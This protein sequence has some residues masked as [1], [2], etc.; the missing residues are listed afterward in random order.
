MIRSR[1][2]PSM[3]R[4]V[5][6]ATLALQWLGSMSGLK[7]ETIVVHSGSEPEFNGW[8]VVPSINLATTF[9]QE[10]P[11]VK[12]GRDDPNS[13]GN[14]FFYSRQANPT[15]GAFER[16]LAATE[17][18]NFCCAFSSGCHSIAECRRSRH[19]P[20]RSIWRDD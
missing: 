10:Y 20:G 13:Y 9:V 6:C 5:V 18:A 11:G 17:R 1:D 3:R 4:I 19:C 8:S 15:R 14:G 2:A 16:A 12:P 7:I